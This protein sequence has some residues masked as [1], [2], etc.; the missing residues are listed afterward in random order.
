MT[1]W[2]HLLMITREYQARQWGKAMRQDKLL[3]R[4]LMNPMKMGPE[5]QEIQ[6]GPLNQDDEMTMPGNT[7]NTE[8]LEHEAREADPGESTIP[9]TATG[10][11]TPT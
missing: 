11:A 4:P 2:L 7:I 3:P 9:N 10:M 6:P 8:S 5:W 1:Q